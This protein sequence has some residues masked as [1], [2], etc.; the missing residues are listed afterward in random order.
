VIHPENPAFRDRRGQKSEKI[1]AILPRNDTNCITG[2]CGRNEKLANTS[3][4]ARVKS[5]AGQAGPA[6]PAPS[7]NRARLDKDRFA[8]AHSRSHALMHSPSH[9]CA[10]PV[11][12]CRSDQAG[13]Q[14]L[15]RQPGTR[16]VN[17]AHFSTAAAD[18]GRCD[19]PDAG[20]KAIPSQ[21]GRP[22]LVYG[23]CAPIRSVV[24]MEERKIR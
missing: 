1:I 4:Q 5:S 12:S 11:P 7:Q 10:R 18:G 22:V 16:P 24:Q 8:P 17:L 21:S 13:L 2:E 3:A 15:H 19:G 9:A 20:S 6:R 23:G 14:A